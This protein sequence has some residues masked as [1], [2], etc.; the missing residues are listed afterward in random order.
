MSAAEPIYFVRFAHRPVP[1]PERRGRWVW[2]I[3]D[4]MAGRT[5]A[6]GTAL[7]QRGA[8]RR[9]ERAYGRCVCVTGTCR[10]DRPVLHPLDRMAAH[11]ITDRLQRDDIPVTV[12]VDGPDGTVVLWPA[13][14]LSTEQ[15]VRALHAVLDRT[16][17]PVRWAGV[18]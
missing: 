3:T 4:G 14:A 7:T 9:Q 2:A 8:V 1:W 5:I 16:D 13:L 10:A 12:R 11:A 15:E 17:S 18:A 6:K